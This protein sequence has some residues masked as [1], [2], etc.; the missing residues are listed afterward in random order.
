MPNANSELRRALSALLLPIDPA[1]EDDAVTAAG[2][3]LAEIA[4]DGQ[5]QSA[6]LRLE[7][8]RWHPGGPLPPVISSVAQAA[9]LAG[10]DD[11]FANK[12]RTAWPRL[13]QRFESSGSMT[14][15]EALA[16]LSRL[17]SMAQLA[18]KERMSAAQISR[19][20]ASTDHRFP[21]TWQAV[22]IAL[23]ELG[24]RPKLT[25]LEV[26]GVWAADAD[27]ELNAFADAGLEA[28]AAEVSEMGRQLGFPD[29][30]SQ[31]FWPCSRWA[32]SRLGPTSRFFTISVLSRTSTT[33]RSRRSMS[34]RRAARRQILCSR[35]IR[36]H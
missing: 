35:G 18:G 30:P 17:R 8:Q 19:V 2:N 23:G 33:M 20:I 27:D 6:L 24:L 9:I 25:S 34:S 4:V 7:I 11:T 32:V 21:V 13:V 28:A 22:Q 36:R 3:A 14:R 1:R 26:E 16:F 29:D 12:L 10:N 5:D 31:Y 15:P